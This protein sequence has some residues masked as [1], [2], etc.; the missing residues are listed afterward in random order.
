MRIEDLY[1]TACLGRVRIRT[2]DAAYKVK[3]TFDPEHL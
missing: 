3:V 1:Q 2:N